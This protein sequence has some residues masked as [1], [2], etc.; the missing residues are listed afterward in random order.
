MEIGAYWQQGEL[1]EILISVY[2]CRNI[3]KVYVVFFRF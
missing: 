3:F 1:G 2:I